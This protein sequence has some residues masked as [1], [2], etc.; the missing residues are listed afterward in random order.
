MSYI[1]FHDVSYAQG[2]YDMSS[3]PNPVIAMKM[4]GFYYGS[5]VGYYD[6]QAGNNYN[7]AIRTSKIPILYHFA[8]GADPIVEADYFV[9]A[10]SPLADGDI[11]ALDYE[12]TADM[13][14]PA[15]PNNWCLQFCERV[16]ERTGTWPLFYTYT[17]MQQQYGFTAVLQNSGFWQAN[18]GVS[19]DA[20]IPNSPPYIIQ[21][22]QGSPL[23][24]NA[25]FTDLDTLRKYGHNAQIQEP[26]PAP[27]PT[28]QPPAPNPVPVPEPQPTIT[29]STTTTTL[30]PTTTTTTLPPPKPPVVPSTS[31]RGVGLLSRFINWLLSLLHVR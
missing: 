21:Q 19:P 22:Y 9:G 15:D 20:D 4:S 11:Y 25:L 12:L 6:A 14:P 29:T 18:Y 7:N 3:D 26:A 10:I 8:G 2:V 1:T 16:H 17:A 31:T 28:P 24:T 27:T 30:P 13:N 23:D 5:K